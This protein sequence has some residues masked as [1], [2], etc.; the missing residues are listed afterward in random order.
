MRRLSLYY[1][2]ALV[3]CW[4]F[5][6]FYAA[7]ADTGLS[8][9]VY[10]LYALVLTAILCT[11]V[12]AGALALPARMGLAWSVAVTAG[13]IVFFQ[14]STLAAMLKWAGVSS[15]SASILLFGAVGLVVMVAG[16]ALGMSRRGVVAVWLALAAMIVAALIQ[17]ATSLFGIAQSDNSSRSVSTASQSSQEQPARSNQA[18]NSVFYIVLDTYASSETIRDRYGYDMSV[19]SDALVSRGF[20]VPR[21][22]FSNYPWTS[23]SMSSA[24]EQRYVQTSGERQP[25]DSLESAR[26]IS[27]SNL[28][29]DT[30]RS[31][32]YSYV[33]FSPGRYAT[34][35]S[36]TGEV[37]HCLQCGGVMS[38]A[39]ILLL[40]RTPLS[41][42]MRRFFPAQYIEAYGQCPISQLGQEAADLS[43]RPMYLL[44]HHMAL[45]DPMHVASDCT[46]LA[47]PYPQDWLDSGSEYVPW[48]LDCLNGQVIEA[49]DSLVDAFDD[50]I[51]VITGD[52]G[53]LIDAYDD[54]QPEALA[55]RHGIYTA[56]RLPE[57]C[58]K[59][60]PD[61]LTPVN[62]YELIV[63]CLEDRK[64]NLKP[65]RFFWT[66][67]IEKGVSNTPIEVREFSLEK[68]D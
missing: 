68:A 54:M 53:I 18:E 16:G 58:R 15:V 6:S 10:P 32:D 3:S 55:L 45:H 25:F 36:C 2:P 12:A 1:A 24:A 5:L 20:V 23:L 9:G 14:Y 8:F 13:T 47:T 44:A 37:D 48:Q 52:H 43:V 57:T 38:E 64:P 63:A 7:N 21:Q 31:K 11:A 40:E 26:T 22:S 34:T 51:I 66:R 28:T 33:M 46:P 67:H 65:D 35:L 62:H 39:D 19:L 59:T 42:L 56:M 29:L 61:T 4:I 17:V 30:F 60:I 49:V 27:D 50:P 41:Q